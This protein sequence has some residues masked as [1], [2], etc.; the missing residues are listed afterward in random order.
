MASNRS[1]SN[2]CGR[3]AFRVQESELSVSCMKPAWFDHPKSTTKVIW[4][5]ALSSDNG[6]V[7]YRQ[8]K[9]PAR[10]KSLKPAIE[11]TR[12]RVFSTVNREY[13]Q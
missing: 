11:E 6:H 3:T 5:M 4:S 12:D 2:H 10:Y 7:A 1:G 9:L 8:T 13:R